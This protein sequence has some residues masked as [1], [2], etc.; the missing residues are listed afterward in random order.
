MHNLADSVSVCLI[1]LHLIQIW[2]YTC[3]LYAFLPHFAPA[4]LKQ[5]LNYEGKVEGRELPPYSLLFSTKDMRRLLLDLSAQPL[6]L[7]YR[8]AHLALQLKHSILPVP[9]YPPLPHT[10][11][12]MPKVG[13]LWWVGVRRSGS[14]RSKRGF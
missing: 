14:I 4:V 13:A 7:F 11:T 10:G 8:L 5:W 9:S 6:Q 12:A 2:F 3:S 1:V